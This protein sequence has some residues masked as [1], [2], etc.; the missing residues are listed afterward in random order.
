MNGTRVDECSLAIDVTNTPVTP[1]TPSCDAFTASDRSIEAGDEITL[2]WETTKATSV[3]MNNGIG[4]V[5]LDGTKKVSPTRDTTY[6]L[7]AMNGT[8][9]DQC[10]VDITVTNTPVTQDT[11]RCE[12]TASDRTIE[13]GDETTLSW[14]NTRTDDIILKDNHGRTLVDT[15]NSSK[16]DTDRDSIKVEPTRD[17]TYT[18]IAKNGS[19]KDECTVKVSVDE[20][21]GGSTNTKTPRCVF[22]ISDTQITSGQ[23][24]VLSWKNENTDSLTLDDSYGNEILNS[25]NDRKINVDK[26]GITL[27][28]KRSTEYT[29]TVK[30]GS[31]TRDCNVEVTVDGLVSVAGVRTQDGIYLNSVPYT[32][33]DT[34]DMLTMI[35]YGAGSLWGSVIAYAFWMKKKAAIAIVTKGT[36]V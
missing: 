18:L 26:G 7:T 25:K 29:L 17:T 22:T 30:D 16:Y 24:V 36:L 11:P 3:S 10:T 33:F 6:I 5:S 21:N 1:D 2:S 19:R 15:N 8:R 35:L 28:P 4:N 13:E 20:D 31:R 23:K 12:L 27:Y 32:G 14:N 34:S 9:Q